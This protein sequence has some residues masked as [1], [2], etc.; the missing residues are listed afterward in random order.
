MKHLQ[1]G[2][3]LALTDGYSADLLE[4]SNRKVGLGVRRIEELLASSPWLVGSS[5]SLADVDAFAICH[6]L[7]TLTPGVVNES[8]T[9][10]LVGW[11]TRIRE[12]P[13]VQAALA[14]SRTGKP[15]EAF[16]PGSEHS[17]W[18]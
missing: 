16:V 11:L 10:R 3:K 7:T 14:M 12:R 8:A 5:Y 13:A 4:D 15:H 1:D 18:G 6:A 17:R 2:W 9:P